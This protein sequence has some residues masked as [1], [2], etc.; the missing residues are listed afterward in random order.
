MKLLC[1][2]LLFLA[3]SGCSGADDKPVVDVPVPQDRTFGF[4]VDEDVEVKDGIAPNAASVP[5][6]KKLIEAI[7]RSQPIEVTR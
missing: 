6:E 3:L 1:A 7:I 2:T 5:T 4:M